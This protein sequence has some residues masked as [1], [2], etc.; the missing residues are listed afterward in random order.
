M[1]GPEYLPNAQR[2]V[3]PDEYRRQLEDVVCAVDAKF[4][5]STW[6]VFGKAPET[7]KFW[8]LYALTK[9]V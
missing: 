8:K 3:R 7:V 4:G 9:E 1:Q 2:T 6:T 5:D